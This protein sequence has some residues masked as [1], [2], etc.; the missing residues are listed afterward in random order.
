MFHVEGSRLLYKLYHIIIINYGKNPSLIIVQLA[1]V[2]FIRHNLW[3]F[4]CF[5][6]AWVRI[7]T[8]YESQIPSSNKLLLPLFHSMLMIPNIFL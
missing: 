1:S 7:G 8:C 2:F 6:K 5:W 4:F 3:G